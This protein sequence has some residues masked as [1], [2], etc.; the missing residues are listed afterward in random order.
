MGYVEP[1]QTLLKRYKSE[2]RYQNPQWQQTMLRIRNPAKTIPFYENNFGMQLIHEYHFDD[3]AF[4]FISS[5]H[6]S[7]A[8][9]IQNLA[10]KNQKNY[11]GITLEL[12]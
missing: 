5:V 4:L 6:Q 3:M 1:S 7:L 2:L 12:H 8:L 9:G 11:Y 10:Q